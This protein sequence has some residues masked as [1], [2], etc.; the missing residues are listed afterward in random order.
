M[1]LPNQLSLSRLVLACVLV[2]LL[3]FPGPATLALALL[4]FVVGAVTDFLDGRI[5]RA[6]NLI[7]PFGKL[8][9]PLAD[10]VLVCAAFVMML[11]LPE[12]RIPAWTVV[13]ILAREFLVTG[14]RGLAAAE[15]VVMAA[16]RG[17]KLK[18]VLQMAYV[19]AFLALAALLP[20][21]PAA[22]RETYTPVVGMVSLG[23]ASAVA[24]LTLYTGL[25]YLRENWHVLHL[26]NR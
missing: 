14:L 1:N 20:W 19:V 6:R 11:G 9:D 18:T 26:Q 22:T 16:N 23:T 25:A 5:A 13:A 7:T 8:I 4:V 2:A 10:K 15:G 21:L 24:L 17:G 12:L 3:S